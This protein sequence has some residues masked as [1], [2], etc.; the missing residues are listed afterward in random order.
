MLY[1]LP[2]PVFSY[3]PLELNPCMTAD[4]PK[5][6]ADERQPGQTAGSFAPIFVQ[7]VR[8]LAAAVFFLVVYTLLTTVFAP[9]NRLDIT[10]SSEQSD[11]V[12]VYHWNG[13]RK[14]RFQEKF[15]YTSKDYDPGTV[16]TISI[17]HTPR[18]L[19]AVRIDPGEHPGL[20]R[21]YAITLHNSLA[22]ARTYDAQQIHR[23]FAANDQVSRYEL[24]GDHVLMESSGIDPT[25][26]A[27][28]P[29]PLP[30]RIFL[31]GLS[32]LF[33]IMLY[34]ASGKYT[35][36]QI[37]RSLASFPA[38][39]DINSKQPAEGSN[40]QSLDGLRGLAALYV[41][42]E[43]STKRFDGLGGLGVCLFFSL[44]GF[45]LIKPFLK[46][47]SR[48]LSPQYMK[49]FYLRRIK[50]ILPVYATYLF[51][52]YFL[53]FRFDTFFRHLFFLQGDKHL[54]AMPQEMF[55]YLLIP[56]V[57]LL[58]HLLYRASGRAALVLFPLLMVLAH[59]GLFKIHIIHN[60]TLRTELVA[61]I[62]IFLGGMLV[63]LVVHLLINGTKSPL[64]PALARSSG[65]CGAVVLLFFSL[66]ASGVFGTKVYALSYPF[67]FD[68]LAAALILSIMLS[69]G[70]LFNRFLAST[71]LRAVGLVSYSFYI[72][73]YLIIKLAESFINYY[74]GT[75]L[76]ENILL[77]ITC[78]VTYGVASFCYSYIEKPFIRPA[79]PKSAGS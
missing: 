21:I 58:F 31:P 33:S 46:D 47:S 60:D 25:L 78:A 26:T 12:K 13:L 38:F 41:L 57:L 35:P 27:A 49:E 69:P 39:H 56:A 5:K 6:E 76:N 36:A 18:T 66:L 7:A 50:R 70:T 11:R 15:S 51:V 10:L 4:R 45:L 79:L 62:S 67:Y 55:F 68:L 75:S 29:L 59:S 40:I 48:I 61:N 74:F 14:I 77:L 24:Q 64:S 2:L 54:W 8:L 32:L 1:S 9:Y 43:H 16:Q 22:G 42:A 19:K 17:R 30:Y 44:S 52:V 3:D 37:R 73:H 71:P 65:I 72:V 53:S 63:S 28:L 34:L 23:M 20:Y